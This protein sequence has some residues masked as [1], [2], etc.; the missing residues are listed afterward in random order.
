MNDS[1]SADTKPVAIITA[2]G[3]GI[4]A[5]CARELAGRGHR[6]ALLARSTAV[7]DLAEQL[8][9]IAVQG[10]VTSA[11]DL[12]R[13]VHAALD[14]FGRIDAVVNNTGHPA[15]GPLLE[16]T[17]SEWHEGLDLLMLGVVRM[18]R[19]VTPVMRKQGGGAIVNVSSFAA[20]EPSLPRPVSSA[21]RAALSSFTKMFADQ[22][23]A[24]GIRMNS[25]LPGWVETS[26]VAH[27]TVATIPM[28]RAAQPEEIARVV[29]FLLSNEASYL[30]GENLR[31]DGSLLRAP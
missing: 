3:A 10:S 20:Q 17:D 15:K 29:A 28:K 21:L 6:V 23:A 30:T 24:D 31:V 22:Y 1:S 5:A 9:G 7:L 4:G 12:E 16:I 27:E 14:R 18:A 11:S 19:L 13:L 8:G 2:A 25:V 26:P